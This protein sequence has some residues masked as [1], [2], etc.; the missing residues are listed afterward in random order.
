M[1]KGIALALTMLLMTSACP[2]QPAP[3]GEKQKTFLAS[4][5]R[6]GSMMGSFKGFISLLYATGQATVSCDDK[7]ALATDLRTPFHDFYKPTWSEFF[8]AIARQTNTSWHYRD[9]KWGW[10]FSKPAMPLPYTIKMA[11]GWTRQVKGQEVNY[12]PPDVPVGMDVYIMG[13]YSAGTKEES[14]A[15]FA[16]VR[17]ALAMQFARLINKK[18]ALKDMKTVKVDGVDALTYE[19]PTPRPGTTWRQ[20]A[21]VKHGRAFIIVSAIDKANERKILPQVEGMVKSFRVAKVL[22]PGAGTASH[23]RPRK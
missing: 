23:G 21:F 13:R 9:E 3:L 19:T 7:S 2:A 15:L 18:A 16:K 6:S 1:R 14:D 10:M 8:D 22:K 11:R 5:L 17:G 12:Y 20:W 4:R